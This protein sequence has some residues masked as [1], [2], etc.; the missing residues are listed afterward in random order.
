MNRCSDSCD[1]RAD[2]G[3]RGGTLAALCLFIILLIIVVAGVGGGYGWDRVRRDIQLAQA[4]PPGFVPKSVPKTQVQ[5]Y[6][7]TAPEGSHRLDPACGAAPAPP[8]PTPAGGCFTC[9]KSQT[10]APIVEPSMT[11][12]PIVEPSGTIAPIVEPSGTVAPI[13]ETLGTVAPIVEPSTTFVPVLI[14]STP[15]LSPHFGT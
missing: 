12:A 14:K 10:F 1:C 5:K 9:K 7:E 8:S 3:S 6:M 2:R 4:C 11:I 13:V 15:D